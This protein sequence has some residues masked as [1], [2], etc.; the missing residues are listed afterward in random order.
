MSIVLQ[1]IATHHFSKFLYL[2]TQKSSPCCWLTQ[3]VSATWRRLCF[4]FSHHEYVRATS[5]AKR[6][7]CYAKEKP[8]T[9]KEL[10]RV[11]AAFNLA[12][13]HIDSTKMRQRLQNEFNRY[14][15]IAKNEP[16]ASLQKKDSTSAQRQPI[17]EESIHQE[18][19]SETM[20]VE[21]E[22]EPLAGTALPNAAEEGQE[23]LEEA[24]SQTT[25]ALEEK[26]EEEQETLAG[27][28][29][30]SEAEEGQKDL[31]EAA[32]QTTSSL[33]EKF[34][35]EQEPL[36]DTALPSEA[37]EGQENLEKPA[38]QMTSSVEEEVE[39]ARASLTGTE[40][41]ISDDDANTVVGVQESII[42]NVLPEEEAN[43]MLQ[44]VLENGDEITD[45]ILSSIRNATILF[46]PTQYI[47][48]TELLQ[49]LYS[50]CQFHTVIFSCT[51]PMSRE[52]FGIVY[53]ENLRSI[54]LTSIQAFLSLP[55]EDD[56][57]KLFIEK[58]PHGELKE[59]LFSAVKFISQHHVFRA[60][61]LPLKKVFDIFHPSK[62]VKNVLEQF[63]PA[64][65]ANA[66]R[67]LLLIYTR[68]MSS[69]SDQMAQAIFKSV[70]VQLLE[71]VI[72]ML[73]AM[74]KPP[75]VHTSLKSYY[76]IR[77][78]SSIID[79]EAFLETTLNRVEQLHFIRI[80]A[81]STDFEAEH[82]DCLM[83]FFKNRPEP[84]KRKPN[85]E[86]NASQVRRIIHNVFVLRPEHL[87]FMIASFVKHFSDSDCFIPI[88]EQSLD[89]I[90]RS[91]EYLEKVNFIKGSSV[92]SFLESF[93]Q[94]LRQRICELMRDRYAQSK[95]IPCISST[96]LET[97]IQEV[98]AA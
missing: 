40:E 13:R 70:D 75:L 7:I 90:N 69:T 89:D 20:G 36:A 96:E 72:Q 5:L 83:K 4:L 54:G 21:A 17:V 39:E 6:V 73:E 63:D 37:E 8:R 49:K 84:K 59:L 3:R 76:F 94:A 47:P 66:L 64:E 31:E 33:E 41:P 16:K 98:L 9:F 74:P 18:H 82:C 29:L 48:S 34:E 26:F 92:K 81:I 42:E 51:Q 19:L 87:S 44:Q 2:K 77:A 88:L 56:Q 24:A 45:N 10:N 71:N 80:I 57:I 79:K 78:Y 95:P 50:C 91:K 85:E 1:G 68:N 28:A 30:P 58:I 22:Q 35:E 15:E 52:A 55:L 27:T 25:S 14:V 93:P 60:E 43:Q 12:C 65:H 97:I 86:T 53:H 67:A 38:S 32:S 46:L 62:I 11:T 23:T 61:L